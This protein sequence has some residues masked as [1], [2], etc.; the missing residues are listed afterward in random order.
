MMVLRPLLIALGLLGCAPCVFSQEPYLVKDIKP[1]S[2][3]SFPIGIA[4]KG[5]YLFSAEDGDHGRELWMSDGSS[6]GTQMIKDIN[7]IG[8]SS[9]GFFV[10]MK[11]Y[12]FFTADDGLHGH[13][14]WK[15]DGT[16]EGTTMMLDIN[17]IGSASS[18]PS[19]LTVVG[20][21]FFLS[22]NDGINGTELWKSDG[23]AGGTALVK[24][25]NP[26]GDSS[27]I[28]IAFNQLLAFTTSTGTDRSELWVS[29]GSE[30]GTVRVLDTTDSNIRILGQVGDVL[31]INVEADTNSGELWKSDGTEEGTIL[32]KDLGGRYDVNGGAA[33]L[34]DHLF[35]IAESSTTTGA[36]LWK[37]NGT[38]DGTVIIRNLDFSIGNRELTTFDNRIFFMAGDFTSAFELWSSDGT[39]EGTALFK[40]INEISGSSA[41]VLFTPFRNLL[42]FV[43]SDGIHGRELWRSDGSSEG[44]RLVRD[45]NPD[46]E[47]TGNTTGYMTGVNGRL[48]FVTDEGN[49]LG[50]E[51]YAIL[52]EETR[53]A[54]ISTRGQVGTGD[55]AMIAGIIIEGGRN[56]VI[57]RANGP[58]LDAHGVPDTLDDPMLQIF[59]G[60]EQ[61]AINDNWRDTQ[62]DEIIAS[63]FAP[64]SDLE[65]AVILELDEGPYTAIVTGV[66]GTIGNAII[67]VFDLE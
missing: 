54:N 55:N 14:L 59:S 13:E 60:A 41:P 12:V 15:T 42:F 7:P 8:N 67:E 22:A 48:F 28:G 44:T 1:G 64:G 50:Q 35:F 45:M 27:P 33:I 65:S 51:L 36:V 16:P 37:S 30:E 62:E 34:G 63:G 56:R 43:A 26:S 49:D 24:D 40:D 25:I 46:P 58:S 5:Q 31:Y 2:E 6:T 38:A 47:F 18:L 19:D 3:N 20:E 61:I 29:D 10:Q 11:D 66:G 57:I 4:Y 53:L 9:P 23:T 21:I 52:V 17:T 39:E 32:V